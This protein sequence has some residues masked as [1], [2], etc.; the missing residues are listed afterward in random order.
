MGI[1]IIISIIIG[2]IF[3][4]LMEGEGGGPNPIALCSGR[5]TLEI[6]VGEYSKK[7]I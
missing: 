6:R 7:N 4:F 2:N 5:Y 1:L 3:I